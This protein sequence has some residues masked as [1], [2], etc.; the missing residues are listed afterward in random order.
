MLNQ[1]ITGFNDKIFIFT[2]GGAGTINVVFQPG[3]EGVGVAHVHS[4]ITA[5]DL[6]KPT[7]E[8]SVAE[9][10]A[11]NAGLNI[12]KDLEANVRLATGENQLY[13]YNPH[14]QGMIIDPRAKYTAFTITTTAPLDGWERHSAMGNQ[15]VNQ[16]LNYKTFSYI[17]YVNEASAPLALVSLQLLTP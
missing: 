9:T 13:G 12:G 15:D 3:Y 17:F 4:T 2:A 6:V 7:V 14:G 16:Q 10:T 1:I 8:L 5:G 11:P